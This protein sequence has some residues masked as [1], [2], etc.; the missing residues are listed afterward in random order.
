MLN[1]AALVAVHFFWCVEQMCLKSLDVIQKLVN[2]NC[3]DNQ[4]LIYTSH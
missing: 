1:C 2:C 4:S 3:L